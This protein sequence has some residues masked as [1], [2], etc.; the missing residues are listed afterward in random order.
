MD[1][2]TAALSRAWYA[3]K[4]NPGRTYAVIG[5][6][7]AMLT[8]YGLD[9]DPAPLLGFLAILLGVTE[10]ARRKTV[11]AIET[12]PIEELLLAEEPDEEGTWHAV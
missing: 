2:L 11:P 12:V 4:R 8:G 7:F 6:F 5:A 3:V 9:V 10:M 1:N